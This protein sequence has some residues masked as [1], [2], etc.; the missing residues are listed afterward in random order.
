MVYSAVCTGFLHYPSQYTL[1]VERDVKQQIN[2]QIEKKVDKSIFFLGGGGG[3]EVTQGKVKNQDNTSEINPISSLSSPLS[4]HRPW[5]LRVQTL[6]VIYL[7]YA[8]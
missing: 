6:L 3:G 8:F 2:K 4:T 1:A 5:L 7:I